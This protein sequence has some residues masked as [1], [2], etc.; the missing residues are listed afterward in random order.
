MRPAN[1]KLV[2]KLI[3]QRLW[4]SSAAPTITHR[5]GEPLF[6]RLGRRRE[7][8]PF[9]LTKLRRVLVVRLDKIGDVALSTSFLRELRRNVPDASITLVVSPAA[10]PLVTSCPY[11]DEVQTYD[12]RASRYFGPL[13]HLHA[14]AKAGRDLWRRRFDLAIVP[15]W[16]IDYYLASFLAY[17]SGAP[18]RLGYSE[19]VTGA[20]QHLNRGF[21]R[22]F[23]HVSSD[24]A[25]KH[26]V[27]HNLDLLRFIGC[28]IERDELEL[29]IGEADE[30]FA[31]ALLR[32]RDVRSDDLLIA[33]APGAGSPKRQWP[34][35]RFGALATW[36][37]EEFAAKVLIVGGPGEEPLGRELA[38]TL[39]DRGID[40]VGR[41]T[42][43]Q[44]AALLRQ[45]QLFIGNDSGPMHVAA[46][47]GVP[48]IEISCHPRGGSPQH[49]NSPKRFGPWGK[50]HIVIQPEHSLQPCAE[51]CVAT[52]AHCITGVS[53]EQVKRAASVRLARH[54][55][56][57]EAASAIELSPGRVL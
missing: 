26:E 4:F 28:D 6:Q 19:R 10:H 43:G 15:C 23:T 21:D 48:V 51:S 16:G 25:V 18:W 34:I 3:A 33:L 49:D 38:S 50:G 17:F 57:A 20:K 44:S 31:T 42:I 36:L 54:R 27:E 52:I 12:W 45:C 2:P 14:L 37:T 35:E 9:D 24:D 46:A 7:A 30:Q 1:H 13:H 29:W 41:T 53:L 11:V 39:D 8:S 55:P 5:L 32:R 22:L 40:V 47:T 56:G